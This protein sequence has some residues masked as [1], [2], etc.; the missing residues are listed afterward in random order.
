[1]AALVGIASMIVYWVLTLFVLGLSRMREYYADR[2]SALS[3]E[4][5]ARK[6]SEALAKIAKSTGRIKAYHG[7]SEGTNSFKTLFISD[8]DIAERDEAAIA[9]SRMFR[10]D[11][12]LVEEILS[13]NVSTLDRVVELFSTHPNIVKR[14]QA[15]QRLA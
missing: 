4:E 2:T 13:R 9:A 10:T 3:V 1:L 14:L 6:L 15:L 5:G 11:Q 12:R 7:R 8:P